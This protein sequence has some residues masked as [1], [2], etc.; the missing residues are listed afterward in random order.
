MDKCFDPNY[1]DNKKE[2]LIYVGKENK[3]KESEQTFRTME[4][5]TSQKNSLLTEKNKINNSTPIDFTII[6]RETLFVTPGGQIKIFCWLIEDNE[7]RGIRGLH[8][9]RRA[10]KGVY[11]SEEVTLNAK[12]IILLKNFLNNIHVVD[13]SNKSSFK[14]PISE[15]EEKTNTTI[16]TDTEFN[17]II[18]ANIKSTDD[19]YKLLSIQKMELGIERLEHIIKGDYDHETEIQKF[20]K[21]HIWMFGNDY[22]FIVENGKINAKNILDLM[23]RNIESYVDIVE[24]KLPNTKLFNYDNSHSN[25]YPTADLTKA[26]SQTQNYIFELEKKTTDEEYQSLRNCKIIKPKGIIVFGSDQPL[27]DSEM[28]Y[29][30]IL[31]SSYHN[32]SILTYQQLLEKAKTTMN[33]IRDI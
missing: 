2:D 32:L 16:I 6:D 5:I 8:L 1:D 25:Y 17:D 12:S 15:I 29:L 21:G 3:N 33:F 11:G 19:F 10:S 30:R 23:P 14:V 22:A 24:V 28:E 20:L 9:S 13:T 4:I 27:T 31:N 18:K 7:K 26:I